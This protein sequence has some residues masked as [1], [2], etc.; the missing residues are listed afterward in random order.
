[1]IVSLGESLIDLIHPED[2]TTPEARIGG[3]PYNVAIALARL[4]VDAGLLCPLSADDYGQMLCKGLQDNGVQQCVAQR[5]EVPTAVAEVFTDA[6]GHPRYAFHRDNTA[7]RDLIN[8]PPIDAL[9]S[10]LT[11]LHFGSL[12]LAQAR[13]WPAWRTA[14][15]H[16]RSCGAFIAFDPNL[17]INLI[18]DMSGYRRRLEEAIELAD[19]IKASDEDLSLLDPDCDPTQRIQRWCSPSRMVVMTR[20]KDGAQL[21]TQTGQRV[22]HRHPGSTPIVDTVGAG[23]T[24]QA[25]A[26]A[27]LWHHNA[28]GS[29][30]DTGNA[31]RLLEFAT[32]AAFVNC[33]RAGCQPPTLHDV[34]GDT[35]FPARS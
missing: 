30:L 28:F 29:T 15:E 6:N 31:K 24:F 34:T 1:M 9:P 7:D 35:P 26:L 4:G 33:T 16:A 8:H 14:I 13:D 25:A 5:S 2:G 18:D 3:S 11:A 17:R 27:W 19:F 10:G 22:K 20:G 32:K 12:V 21:W 23:D